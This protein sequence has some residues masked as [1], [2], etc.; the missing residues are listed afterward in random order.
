MSMTSVEAD[1]MNRLVGYA[2]N[3]PLLR[4]WLEE[5]LH[6]HPAN[7]PHGEQIEQRRRAIETGWIYNQRRMRMR[8][9][10]PVYRL[11]PPVIALADCDLSADQL[12]DCLE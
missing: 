5:Q 12:S 3:A 9:F 7:N 11:H 1:E 6:A 4:L 10:V 8:D 2:G